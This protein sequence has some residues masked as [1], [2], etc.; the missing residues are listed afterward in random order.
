MQLGGKL[1]LEQEAC[2][3]GR[4]STVAANA[5]KADSRKAWAHELAPRE[6]A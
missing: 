4:E 3:L 2:V 5:L 1:G 6:T